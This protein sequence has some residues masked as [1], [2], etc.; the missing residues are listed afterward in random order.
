ME[1]TASQ[2]DEFGATLSSSKQ[3]ELTDEQIDELLQ[4]AEERLRSKAAVK[5]TT[6]EPELSNIKIPKLNYANLP[7]APVQINKSVARANISSLLPKDVR[8]AEG[9]VRKVEDPVAVKKRITEVCYIS[10]ERTI[11]IS[12]MIKSNTIFP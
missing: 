10:H 8:Q 4:R 1:I 5:T 6:V 9:R 3:K 12:E 7:Q 11:V 2:S